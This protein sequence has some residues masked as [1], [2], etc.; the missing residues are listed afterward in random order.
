MKTL[1]NWGTRKDNST[2][3]MTPTQGSKASILLS[4]IQIL[5]KRNIIIK[6]KK[7]KHIRR[8]RSIRRRKTLTQK[9]SLKRKIAVT[10]KLKRSQRRRRFLRKKNPKGLGRLQR[11]V[12]HWVVHQVQLVRIRLK[13]NHK[14][15]SWTYWTHQAQHN[16][17]LV[18]I[19]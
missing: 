11:Q 1:V 8:K 19:L 12:E 15:I 2:N 13:I 18:S 17:L 6:R 5:I 3:H 16:N 10:Q 14:W 4:L 9:T 7:K